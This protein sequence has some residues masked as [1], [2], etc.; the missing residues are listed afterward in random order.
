MTIKVVTRTK[1]KARNTPTNIDEDRACRRIWAMTP[2]FQ[3]RREITNRNTGNIIGEASGRDDINRESGIAT[4][5][6]IKPVPKRA[7]IVC[8]LRADKP[9][10]PST[11]EVKRLNRAVSSNAEMIDT[12]GSWLTSVSRKLP[13]I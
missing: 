8:R 3:S 10:K 11:V 13:R 2:I 7:V 4:R 9:L 1:N 6:K 12:A 5:V